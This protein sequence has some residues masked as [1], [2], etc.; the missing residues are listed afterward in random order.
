M[1]Q[2]GLVEILNGG[3][4]IIIMIITIIMAVVMIMTI[5]CYLYYAFSSKKHTQFKTIVQK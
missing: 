1:C 5:L 2:E 3:V 4:C